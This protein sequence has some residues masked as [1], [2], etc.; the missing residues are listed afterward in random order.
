M[1]NVY[2]GNEEQLVE[3]TAPAEAVSEPAALSASSNQPTVVII[4]EA[5]QSL[6]QSQV[7]QVVQ[8]RVD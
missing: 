5:L 6:I 4:L 1:S 3:G 7:N 2:P 8:S